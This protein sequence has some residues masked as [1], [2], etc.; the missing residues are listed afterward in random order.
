[1]SAE[2]SDVLDLVGQTLK[3][4]YLVESK[5]GPGGMAMVYTAMDRTLDRKV[6]IKVP[7]P[8]LPRQSGLRERFVAEV[9]SL[10]ALVHPHILS[11]RDYG[12]FHGDPLRWL[13]IY[14]DEPCSSV[15]RVDLGIV[16][17]NTTLGG[18]SEP[19]SCSTSPRLRDPARLQAVGYGESKPLMT[20]GREYRM[21]RNR[22][23]ELELLP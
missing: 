14:P 13:R 5:I 20:G 17:A 3:A 8:V 15:A 7:H 4:R 11:I 23:V 18:S 19:A 16:P 6:V 1:M 21:C 9:R 22:R 12:D 10:I 2:G